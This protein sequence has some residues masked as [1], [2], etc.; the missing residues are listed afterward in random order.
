[1]IARCDK[2]GAE[3]KDAAGCSHASCGG[4]FFLIDR[5]AERQRRHGCILAFLF[6]MLLWVGLIEAYLHHR[7]VIDW[8]RIEGP[9]QY[10]TLTAL[11]IGLGC[12]GIWIYRRRSQ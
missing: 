2:C 1:M 11:I 9:G 12:L 6:S 8:I 3:V 10:V 7:A 4:I 5:A